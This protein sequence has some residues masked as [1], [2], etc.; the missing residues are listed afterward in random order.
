MVLE[1]KHVS[2][3]KIRMWNTLNIKHEKMFR[4]TDYFEEF[5]GVIFL[6]H[7]ENMV[8]VS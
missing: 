2:L 8:L 1:R 6:F 4:D 7:S 5:K 3:V